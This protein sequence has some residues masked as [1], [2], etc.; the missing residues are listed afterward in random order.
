MPK[1]KILKYYLFKESN[2]GGKFLRDLFPKE[3][4]NS[5]KDLLVPETKF[6][7]ILATNIHE[8]NQLAEQNGIYFGMR[9]CDCDCCGPRWNK[10]EK[11]DMEG[12]V[13]SSLTNKRLKKVLSDHHEDEILVVSEGRRKY[14]TI[15]EKKKN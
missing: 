4:A 2:S 7:L 11:F 14:K 5:S 12:R 15:I 10:I 13:F 3:G 1:G 6:V 9:S 8:A